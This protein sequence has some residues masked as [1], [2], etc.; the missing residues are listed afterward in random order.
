[1]NRKKVLSMMM[2]AVLTFTSV[3]P[4]PALYANA[5]GD[6]IIDEVS[7]EYDEETVSDNDSRENTNG[8]VSG[9]GAEDESVS[10]SNAESISEDEAASVSE[11]EAVSENEVDEET[12]SG[13]AADEKELPSGIKG[14]PEGYALSGR[15]AEIKSDM[16]SHDILA[17]LKNA[18]AGVDYI[19]DQVYCI[20]DTEEYAQQIA[21]AYGIELVEY[22]YSVAIYNISESG[23][24]VYETVELGLNEAYGLPPLTPDYIRLLPAEE[25]DDRFINEMYAISSGQPVNMPGDWESIRELMGNNMD[26]LLMP[27]DP[28]Y[29]WWHDMMDTYTAWDVYGTDCSES[30][31]KV[32]VIDGCVLDSHEDLNGNVKVIDVTGGGSTVAD[33]HGTQMAGIIGAKAGNELGGAGIAPGV[34][35]YSLSS[36]KENGVIEGA[37]VTAGLKYLENSGVNI[38][39]VRFAGD[40][41]DANQKDAIQKAY[42]KNITIIAPAGDEDT[43]PAQYDHVISVGAVKQDGSAMTVSGSAKGKADVYAPGVE[44]VS[45][46]SNGSYKAGTGTPMAAAAATGACAL[47]MSINGAVSPDEMETVL[48]GRTINGKSLEKGTG[49]VNLAKMLGTGAAGPKLELYDLGKLLNTVEGGKSGSATVNSSAYISVIPMSASGEVNS[50]RNVQVFYTINGKKPAF[51]DGVAKEGTYCLVP[52]EGDIDNSNRFRINLKNIVDIIAEKRQKITLRVVTVTEYGEVSKGTTFKLN[53][54]PVWNH[55]KLIISDLPE[56]AYTIAP[57]GTLQ[58]KAQ[59]VKDNY[60]QTK[61]SAANKPKWEILEGADIASFGNKNGLLKTFK[62]KTGEVTIRCSC[63]Y[64]G[65]TYRSMEKTIKVADQIPLKNITLSDSYLELGTGMGWKTVSVTNAINRN[66]EDILEEEYVKYVWKSSNLKVA[67]PT[68]QSGKETNIY[69]KGKGTA[70]ITCTA[71]DG[72]KTSAKIKV[73]VKQKA[74][75]ID[76][77]GQDCIVAGTSVAYK[78]GVHGHVDSVTNKETVSADDKSV[79]WYL[80]DDVSCTEL[81]GGAV[82]IDPKK[83]IVYITE[84]HSL[85]EIY[86]CAIANDGSNRSN[87]KRVR[88]I[89]KKTTFLNVYTIATDDAYQIKKNKNGGITSMQLYTVNA[90]SSPVWESKLDIMTTSDSITEVNWKSSNAAVVEVVDTMGGDAQLWAKGAGSAK[91]TCMADDGSG[92]KYSFK[93]KVIAPV[94]HLMLTNDKLTVY[95]G[96]SDGISYVYLDKGKSTTV[97]PVTGDS[98]GKPTNPKI[99][100]S[101]EIVG[102]D[103]DNCAKALDA[104]VVEKAQ[105]A[106]LFNVKDGR[107]KINKN[108]DK[109]RTEN[110][111]P[112]RI[113]VIITVAATDG[114]NVKDSIMV[115]PE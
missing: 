54:D 74:V 34:Q 65:R 64:K 58:L 38:A 46:Y 48:T 55:V 81:D 103:E 94:S 47:Y 15:E 8:A 98:Y 92:K 18:V 49:I 12:V 2:T 63:K 23:R 112:E 5:E 86:V 82:R 22:A 79:T 100:W 66:D 84:A 16:I 10:D 106:K 25:C 111:L 89:D 37:Y 45:T 33:G 78:A 109:L 26:P 105:K 20:A 107:I 3:V 91:I 56:S 11:N 90:A 42:E 51:K 70:I 83:G 36:A 57:G 43:E 24:D 114:T 14:M 31:I 30:G 71:L 28:N 61:V 1:M 7:E 50:E 80:N 99:K 19:E 115:I 9:N 41:Y 62:G 110:G 76:I 44:M 75:S 69:P 6:I 32:A 101:Y 39:C 4:Q 53:V 59:L 85:K 77:N 108:Y 40:A 29:Q 52:D 88:V 97:K 60:E 27:N 104:A 68:I 102:Y 93:V 67:S 35:I 96:G 21:D 73:T 13:N 113:G 17:A 95:P 72:S 87:R